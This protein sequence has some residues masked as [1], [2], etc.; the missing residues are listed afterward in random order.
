MK[1]GGRELRVLVNSKKV[2]DEEALLICRQM[3]EKIEDELT[4]PGEIRVTVLRE[5]RAVDF[6]R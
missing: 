4:Y 1:M 3:A 5:V 2:T 6:A